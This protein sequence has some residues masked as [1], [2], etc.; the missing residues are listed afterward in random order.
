MEEERFEV[1][2]Q[3]L[4]GT[5]HLMTREEITYCVGNGK[6]FFAD[7]QMVAPS[8]IAETDLSQA[9]HRILA[10]PIKGGCYIC[11]EHLYTVRTLHRNGTESMEK[12]LGVDT[13]KTKEFWIYVDGKYYYDPEDSSI[14]HTPKATEWRLITRIARD[15]ALPLPCQSA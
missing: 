5:Y 12:M 6:W 3:D 4:D 1:L 2:R 10:K 15:V 9:T 14:W 8:A 7:G 11:N 13:F